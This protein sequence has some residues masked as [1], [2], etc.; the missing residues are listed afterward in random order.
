MKMMGTWR[1][2]A[3][4][5]ACSSTPLTAGIWTSVITHDVSLNCADRKKVAGPTQIYT[6][7]IDR[8]HLR[9]LVPADQW[10]GAP[11]ELVRD[12]E[13]MLRELVRVMPASNGNEAP[14]D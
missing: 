5:R 11:I 10:C 2:C 9:P 3:S 12:F 4:K 8:R 6:R 7:R 14:G 1:H 13:Q